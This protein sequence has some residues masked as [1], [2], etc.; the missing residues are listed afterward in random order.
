MCGCISSFASLT[1]RANAMLHGRIASPAN[2]EYWQWLCKYQL[3][4]TS[5]T[6]SGRKA[7][8]AFE[9]RRQGPPP[10][11]ALVIPKTEGIRAAAG[12]GVR[13]DGGVLLH[14]S[15]R[16][17]LRLSSAEY[18][19]CYVQVTRSHCS[20]LPIDY[21]SPLR[22]LEAFGFIIILNYCSQGLLEK[23]ALSQCN[24]PFGS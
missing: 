11:G 9:R 20:C 10:A 17:T 22:S 21:L 16:V 19:T 18:F 24:P 1:E 5:A 15:G 23:G 12:P 4:R 6:S 13:G 14:M 2:R 8:A 7:A 3:I